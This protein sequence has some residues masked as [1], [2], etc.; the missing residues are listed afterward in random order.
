VVVPDDDIGARIAVSGTVTDKLEDRQV[1]VEL[2]ATSEGE[3]VLGQARA[4]VQL[5]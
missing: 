3:K 4:L 1:R 5:A 2:T